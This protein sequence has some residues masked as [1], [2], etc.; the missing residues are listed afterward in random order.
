LLGYQPEVRFDDG[1]AEL[2]EWLAGESAQDRVAQAREEL[3]T[4]GLTV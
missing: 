1:L 3:E 2:A 4:R